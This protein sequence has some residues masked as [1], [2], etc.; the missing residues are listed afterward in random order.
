MT[1]EDAA[2]PQSPPHVHLDLPFADRKAL[3]SSLIKHVGRQ[4][5]PGRKTV[6]FSSKS[7]DKKISNVSDC[8][9]FMQTGSEFVKLRGSNRHFRRFFSLDADLSHIRWTPT[10]KKPHKARIAIEN[11]REV[12]LGKN[13]EQLRLSDS[14]FGDLQDECLFSVIYGDDYE[15]L[16]LVAS[17]ADDANIWVTGLMALTSTKYDCKPTTIAWATLR[18]RWLGSVFDEEDPDRKGFIDE[19]T[20]VQL[21][22]QTNP[23]LALSRIKNKVKEAGCSLDAVERGKIHKDEFVELYKE[24]ATRPEVYFLMVR[25]ANKDYLSCQDL[26]LFLET[27]QGM[28]GVTT[29]FCENVV[30]QYEPSPEAKENNFMTVDGFTAFLLSKDCW[31]FDPSHSRVWMDM[32]QPFSKYFIASSHKTYLV[33]DQ[34][35]P[36]NVDG[37]TSALKRNCR[38]IELDLWDPT[39]SN[40]ETEPM[41]KNGLLALSKIPLSE[42]LK[43]IRQSAFDRSRYPLILRL[44]VHCSC[45]WQKVAA[46][47][48][49]THLGTKLYLPSA[50]PTDWSKEKAIPTPW[51]FQQRILI[52]GKRLCCSS[53]SGEVSED[54]DGIA[55]TSR[56][57]SRRIRLCRELSD[58]VPPF[59]QLKTLQDLMA[60]APNSQTMNPRQHVAY[61]SETTALR[62]THTYAQEFAQTSRDY[63]V[64]VS[65]NVTR[66]DSSNLNPQEF[67]NH[68]IQ[69]VGINYQTPGL[70]VDLQE[71]RF[72]ENGGCGYVLKPSVMNEDLFIAGDKLPNTPQILHLRILSGQQLPRPRGSNAKGDSSDPFVVIEVFGIPGDCAEERTKTIRNDGHNPSFDES[73]QFQV[74]VPE[75]AL[76][77]FLVLDDDFIGDDFIGQYTVPFE[78]LQPGWGEMALLQKV[79]SAVTSFSTAKATFAFK[80]VKT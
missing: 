60:T 21:I 7:N 15:T 44:S 37:L 28:V 25:Y 63:V 14:N 13:T 8:W 46:K 32:K 42:A 1:T 61:L 23:T 27:E 19:N 68:G 65:P 53:E 24:I 62:L 71:G 73:F 45:E 67:W 2:P 79:L 48:L 5:S 70:M 38:V 16:D 29:E 4:K 47:L 22:R 64:C 52:M 3:R 6:S 66:A 17:C 43:T 11:I 58:L 76:V 33:E 56:R 20:A 39:E 18:E 12:R 72:A 50:D 41:V 49:V 55:S 34:Q 75:L 26:R 9:H 69:M 57:K 59:L 78:C 36:A 40:G 54:D 77:R 31:I 51:D 35:G 30:E 80:K 10:N 74:S